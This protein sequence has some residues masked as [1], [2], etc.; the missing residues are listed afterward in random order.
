LANLANWALGT[1][2]NW[3]RPRQVGGVWFYG[4]SDYSAFRELEYL[5]S[6]NEIPELNAVIN[7]KA[8]AFSAGV[9]KAIDNKGN[10]IEKDPVVIRLKKPNWF[11]AEKEFLR[12]TKLFHEIF[13]NEYI[14]S[15]F[16]VGSKRLKTT[17]IYTL[18]P[19]LVKCEYETKTP[20]FLWE[21]ADKSPDGVK[22][23]Y[24]Q[25]TKDKEI[26][27]DQLIHLNDNRVSVTDQNMKQMLCGE[28]KMKGL[29][30]AINNIKMAY[31]T[32]GQILSD[33]GSMGVLSNK[34]ADVAGQIPV[35]KED[36]DEVH[37]QYS[38]MY[39]GLKGQKKIIITNADLRWQEMSVSPDKLGL[40]KE[41]EEDFYKI[42]DA[43]GTPCELFASSKGATYVNKNEARK[44]LYD[45]TTIP[46]TNEWIGA[47][48]NYYYPDGNVRL[49]MDFS[50]LSIFQEDL[51]LNA[52]ALG[53]LVKG[54]SQA[55]A[56]GAIDIPEYQFELN[57]IGLAVGNKPQ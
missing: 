49:I 15:F 14:Y 48:S 8:R 32:R 33:R 9:I 22:Y 53:N 20:F 39:G 57:K 11:Q 27:P 4:V 19:N 35:S 25:D 56:D 29:T 34:S 13:G 54:L 42:C 6:F 47:L 40:F 55:L 18:P 12:Q 37:N 52:A 26:D 2:S 24:T 28:S 17:A 44:D 43:Y 3:F 21:D 16:G 36:R 7:Y 50:H 23:T 5:N 1:I 46:E 10:E 51:E 41:T 30:A 38:G 45:N 31:E